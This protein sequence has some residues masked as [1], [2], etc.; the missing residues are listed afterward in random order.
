MT[1]TKLAKK[2]SE[3][4]YFERNVR[5]IEVLID[6]DAVISG[7]ASR[8]EP[9]QYFDLGH[10]WCTHAY[11]IECPHRMACPK[12][13]FYV[14]K[15]SSIGQLIEGQANLQQM[16]QRIPLT[17]D[18]RAAV[19]EGVEMFESLCQ[20]LADVPTPAG[21]TARQ[22]VQLTRSGKD[23]SLQKGQIVKSRVSET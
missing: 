15:D 17:E 5:T 20:R 10:G 1:P 11:F 18:E 21:P 4:G 13:Q 16:L 22:L 14:P 9:W 23:D 19:E 3:A 2:F 7:A 8:G 12:C 6:K